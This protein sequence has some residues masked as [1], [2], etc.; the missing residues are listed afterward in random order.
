MKKVPI[1][2]PCAIETM[3]SHSINSRRKAITE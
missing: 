2:T 1:I 3:S